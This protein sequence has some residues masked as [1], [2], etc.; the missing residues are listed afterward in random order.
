MSLDKIQKLV[1]DVHVKSIQS[2]AKSLLNI[3]NFAVTYQ[4]R[5]ITNADMCEIFRIEMKNGKAV[6]GREKGHQAYITTRKTQVLLD[7]E[8]FT[9]PIMNREQGFYFSVLV[10]V[11][12][13]SVLKLG[14][15]VSMDDFKLHAR[16]GESWNPVFTDVTQTDKTFPAHREVTVK[17]DG[18]YFKI[19]V[20]FSNPST[21]Y[22][23]ECETLSAQ[24]ELLLRGPNETQSQVSVL[25]DSIEQYCETQVMNKALFLSPRI[26]REVAK[27]REV[28]GSK[29]KREPDTQEYQQPQ[30]KQPR[31]S[32]QEYQQPRPIEP[33]TWDGSS[34]YTGFKYDPSTNNPLCKPYGT[35]NENC[36]GNIN[37]IWTPLRGKMPPPP[38]APTD[39]PGHWLHLVNFFYQNFGRCY[40]AY[41]K[42]HPGIWTNP[43]LDM[44][45]DIREIAQQGILRLS[46][47]G[48]RSNSKSERN[49]CID[50]KQTIETSDEIAQRQTIAQELTEMLIK[51]RL[52]RK[53]L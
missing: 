43:T 2:I 40:D 6:S 32:P 25:Y 51:N 33:V 48:F 19:E 46:T 53:Q 31:P 26:I 49:R 47:G 20:W 36:F 34:L 18:L 39:K 23:T 38:I 17:P 42:L 52:D 1:T 21:R 30:P 10:I 4:D 29:R 27:L 8:D 12:T 11:P 37:Q 9:G 14:M 22:V 13:S 7:V 44:I 41:L 28:P 35:I 50:D 5:E 45:R 16:R 24:L 15:G 3:N